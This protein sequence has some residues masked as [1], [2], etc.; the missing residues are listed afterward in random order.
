MCFFHKFP[1]SD[2]SL[3]LLYFYINVLHLCLN[4]QS[5]TMCLFCNIYS[6]TA[7]WIWKH[8]WNKIWKLTEQYKLC[9]L[10]LFNTIKLTIETD[11]FHLVQIRDTQFF[12][13]FVTR[14]PSQAP[15]SSTPCSSTMAGTTPKKGKDCTK[16]KA[17]KI[18]HE[19]WKSQK[20][21]AVHRSQKNKAECE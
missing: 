16:K 18:I 20:N 1:A 15:S 19:H 14:N 11:Y 12:S 17:N 5:V 10:M 6:K 2:V 3:R 13:L 7:N 21:E 8:N 9:Q 4:V